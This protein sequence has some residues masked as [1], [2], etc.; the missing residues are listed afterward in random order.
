MGR[1]SIRA[2]SD[3]KLQRTV[4]LKFLPDRTGQQRIAESA[5]PP[6]GRG[7]A[8]SL[9]HPNIGRNPTGIE[10]TADGR[11][12]IV[13]GLLRGAETLARQA[14]WPGPSAAGTNSGTSRHPDGARTWRKRNS[15]AIVHSR[16]QAVER[17][18]DASR[19]V[20]K[21]VDFRARAGLRRIR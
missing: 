7:P 21:I 11:T 12:F 20:V 8:S 18:R 5:I 16:H 14:S 6:R 10:E 9:D 17:D 15:R 19:I 13:M 2:P 3:L 1:G 4:A